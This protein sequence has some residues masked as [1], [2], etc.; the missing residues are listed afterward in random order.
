MPKVVHCK[1]ALKGTFVYVG[2][3]GPFGNPFTAKDKVLNG[4]DTKAQFIVDSVEEA[5]SKYEEWL[6]SQPELVARVK[7]DLKGHDLGCWCRHPSTP[8][9]LC[10]ADVLLR[11]ANS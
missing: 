2:R 11:I 10:H 8:D 9:K 5:V 6:L 3:P 4:K 1:I 7:R